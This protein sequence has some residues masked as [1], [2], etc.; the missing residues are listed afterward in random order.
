MVKVRKSGSSNPGPRA[1]CTLNA[2]SKIILA[3]SSVLAGIGSY[4]F[5]KA[6]GVS[7]VINNIPVCEFMI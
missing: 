4:C 5:F 6:D 3:T 7:S 1:E 2:P